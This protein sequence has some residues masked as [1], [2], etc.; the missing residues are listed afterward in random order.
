MLALRRPRNACLTGSCALGASSLRA[1]RFLA[2]GV[3]DFDDELAGIF[4]VRQVEDAAPTVYLNQPLS[5]G[6]VHGR[7][8]QVV[9]EKR[10]QESPHKAISGRVW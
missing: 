9:L 7:V 3:Q 5:T 4:R 6:T 1:V 2:A 10:V 8:E